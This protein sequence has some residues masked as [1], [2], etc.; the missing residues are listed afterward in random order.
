MKKI[1]KIGI[2]GS[3][4]HFKK[5]IYPILKKSK[6][7]KIDS[8]MKFKKKKFET[9][10]L[11]NEKKFFERKLDFVYIASPNTSHDEYII[12]SLKAKWHV[13]CEKPFIINKKKLKEIINLSKKNNKLVFESFM[14]MYHPLFKKIEKLMRSKTYGKLR[15]IISNWKHPSLKKNNNQ[16]IK[17]AGNGFWFDGAS[18]LLSFD[19][20]FF[21]GKKRFI[22]QYIKKNIALRGSITCNSNKISRYY[23]WGEGQSYKNDLELFFEKATIY[24]EQFFAKRLTDI[25]KLKVYTNFSIKEKIVKNDNQ[26]YLMFKDI[27]LNYNKNKYQN[28]HRNKIIYQCN[29]LLK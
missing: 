29:Y 17:K 8:M 16:Y 9:Y 27:Y 14:Y 20:Y 12:K 11:L 2:I 1:L 7:F 6:Y 25:I 18:Y 13:I 24:V 10:K 23:F 26:F 21:K 22:K 19:N 4:N 5:N 15:Y 28:Y 3:G